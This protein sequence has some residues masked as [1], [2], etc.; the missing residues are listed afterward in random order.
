MI[1]FDSLFLF[2]FTSCFTSITSRP[3]IRL[4]FRSSGP[5][6]SKKVENNI[7][8]DV[9]ST[10][11]FAYLLILL[12]ALTFMIPSQ[13]TLAQYQSGFIPINASK[14][15][16]REFPVPSGS[17]PHDV[18]PAKN[19][20]VWYTAQGSGELGLLKPATGKTHHISLGQGSAPHGVI[21]GPDGSPWITDGGL[22]AIVRVNPETEEV[23]VFPLPENVGNPNLNTA[24]FDH[25][26]VLW[27][28]GQSGIYGRLDPASGKM[29]VFNAPRGVGPYGIST[30][31]K[32]SVYF[33][34]L[35]GGYVAHINLNTGNAT[36]LQPPTQDQGAR[37][38]W[39]DSQVR[40]WFSE[41]NAGK[42]GLYN[43]FNN[44]WKEWQL[45][46]NNPQP[47][48]IFVDDKD[49]IWL[50]D[51][52]SNALVRFDPSQ[53]KF[54]VFSLPSPGA[55]VRQLLGRPGEVWGAESG[56]DK[57]VVVEKIDCRCM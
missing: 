30:T 25:K 14:P 24:T 4:K 12:I 2:K 27:F 35:A 56:I 32:G 26:G 10:H 17:Q 3:S 19:G 11:M 53:Q 50:S 34:S 43:P 49:M 51:F 5:D 29:D 52:G 28:T 31:H 16:L 54:E 9:K 15:L 20:S 57:L 38:V 36:V 33:A 47:Y 44:T 22:N 55:N 37:R 45:P 8:V 39:S 18:A 23:R 7:R 6:C 42:L 40:V 48:A 13:L 41:W 21:V 46:G 1:T